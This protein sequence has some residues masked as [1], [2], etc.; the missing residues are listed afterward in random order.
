MKAIGVHVF[1]GGFTMGVQK[2]FDVQAQLEVH[3]FGIETA[4]RNCGIP[5]INCAAKDWPEVEAEFAYGNPRCTGFSTI[6]SGYSDD[7]HGPWARQ[8]CDIHQLCEYTAGRFDIIC[9]E[10]VQQAYTVG[11]PLIR[12][13][14]EKH[15]AP[16]H[17]RIAHVF[18][19][20]ASFGNA[21]NR[22]RYFFMAYRDDRNFNITPPEISAYQPLMADAIWDLRN[23]ETHEGGN[24]FDSYIKLTPNE[25]ACVPHLPNGWDL[26]RL[27]RYRTELTPE[28]TQFKWNYRT[29]AL[30]FSLHCIFRTNWLRPSPT[31]HSSAMRWIHPVHNRPLTIGELATIMGWE[32]K[33][34]YGKGAIP[35]IAK[36]IVPA[37]GTWLAE[38]AKDYLNGVWG[39]DDWES[40]YNAKTATWEG[41]STEGALEKTFDLTDYCGHYFDIERYAHIQ[42]I[43]AHV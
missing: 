32:G 15:F 27:A 22:R 3:G 43:Q 38:Q 37:V 36:G 23:R 20:A 41:R 1:A 11:R 6:T 17:Y 16:K 28:D 12:H 34:P 31:I 21:Q 39:S 42:P 24:D 8:T 9:W 26:N 2:V 10:S 18:V 25:K 33:I 4:E 7:T 14:I 40:S 29:S 5:V 19:N 30:P 35:Q 13:L